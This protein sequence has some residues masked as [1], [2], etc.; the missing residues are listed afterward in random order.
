M[1]LSAPGQRDDAGPRSN[2]FAGPED[3]GLRS[4]ARPKSSWSRIVNDAIV[5]EIR[6][7]REAH[8]AQFNYDLD[9]MFRDIKERERK[10]GLTFVDGVAHL[11]PSIP[12]PP[13]GPETPV[14]DCSP[15]PQS[16]H[17]S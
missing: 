5:D 15:L 9:A 11:P 14:P 7:I 8:A 13:T 12:L 6:R 16:Q 17:S 2:R 10:C 3:F 4:F 1:E